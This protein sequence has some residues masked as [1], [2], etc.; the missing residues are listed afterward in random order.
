[1]RTL[2]GTT[3]AGLNRIY[4]DLRSE[5]TAEPRLRTN[6]LYAPQ[7]QFRPGPDGT[8]PAPGAGQITMLMPP[9]AYTV[10]LSVGGREMTQ[11]LTVRKDPM[12]RK[13]TTTTMR[14]VSV[15]V[16]STSR[17]ALSI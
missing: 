7:P 8:R 13:I 5:P 3:R 15:R 11:A 17:I 16:L 4:W 12:K 6:P 2:A 14:S 9:G 1:M 10:K